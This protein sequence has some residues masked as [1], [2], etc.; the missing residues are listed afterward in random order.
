MRAVVVRQ[1]GGPEELRVEVV[2]EPSP[3]P[4]Q[5]LV[6]VRAAG[7]NFADVLSRRG[8]YG[9]PPPL[10]PGLEAAGTV[11]ALGSGVQQFVVGDRVCGW[12]HAAYAEFAVADERHLF[13]I[14]EGMRFEDAAAF[15]VVF[16]TAWH[17][18][19]VLGGV[20]PGDVVLVHAAGSGVGVAALQLAQQAGAAV[21]ATST[22]EWKRARARSLGA[23]LVV[24][25]R[26]SGW[27]E[28][29]REA[30]G[31]QGVAVALEGVGRPTLPGTLACMAPLGRVI[32]FGAPGGTH[33][34]IDLLAVIQRN[35]TLRGLLLDA[36]PV[37]PQTLAA[38][39]THVL[40]RLAQGALSASVYR[41]LPLHEAAQAHRILEERAAFGKVV[42][43][44][45][46]AD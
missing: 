26:D 38:L 12:V 3:G 44:V 4:G 43:V 30:F 37:F 34:E 27:A 9:S 20:Q 21:V 2:P 19:V 31:G 39:D 18:L 42:L 11:E 17:A 24:D 13:R 15:P 16:G 5:V 23:D 10:I 35:L 22:Q 41:A 46:G 36:D 25:T 33:A 6:R 40:P 32:V 8:R 45:K 14:P 7:V 29:V 28:Q 1:A